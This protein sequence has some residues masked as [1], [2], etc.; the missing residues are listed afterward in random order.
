MKQQLDQLFG[1]LAT[2]AQETNKSRRD[3]SGA[4]EL[5]DAEAELLE[6]ISE[7][8]SLETLEERVREILRQ[9]WGEEEAE[10]DAEEEAPTS[11][12]LDTWR[13]IPPERYMD[14]R[15]LSEVERR[16]VRILLLQAFCRYMPA[17]PFCGRLSQL[18]P[19]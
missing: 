17:Q 7:D 19:L 9:A 6:E 14:A 18:M 15:G 8:L 3:F 2:I 11:S 5:S 1:Y 13:G 16:I 12:E 10:E 4:F